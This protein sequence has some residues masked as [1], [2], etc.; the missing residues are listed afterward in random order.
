MFL[1]HLLGRTVDRGPRSAQP[2]YI[3]L[4]PRRTR[5]TLLW[6]FS[7]IPAAVLGRGRHCRPSLW[8]CAGQRVVLERQECCERARH[9]LSL[10]Q[11]SD[12]ISIT[13][14]QLE[15]TICA[16]EGYGSQVPAPTGMR[17][18]LSLTSPMMRMDLARLDWFTQLTYVSTKLKILDW[19]NLHWHHF[20]PFP[21]QSWY[22]R[23]S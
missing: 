13:S 20:A 14:V 6:A 22:R 5:R 1:L 17:A 9:H 2:E 12:I 18:R 4:H 8:W 10:T 11:R 19:I 21:I 23:L 7:G 3:R 15:G 16:W